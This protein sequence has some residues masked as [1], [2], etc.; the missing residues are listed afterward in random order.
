MTEESRKRFRIVKSAGRGRRLKVSVLLRKE[1]VIRKVGDL[2][3]VYVYDENEIT[4]RSERTG[5]CAGCKIEVL[6]VYR[7]FLCC[8][9]D[10]YSRASLFAL[11]YATPIHKNTQYG[12]ENTRWR[13]KANQ[14]HPGE[15]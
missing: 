1:V 15:P 12:L 11:N 5:R 8:Q 10:S 6:I 4:K 13:P 3:A 2:L 14:M 9:I 7:R